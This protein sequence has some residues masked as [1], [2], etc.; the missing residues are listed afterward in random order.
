[1]KKIIVIGCPGSGKSTL[2]RELH[3]KTGIPLYH[4]DMMYWNPDK[5]T[6]EKQVFLDRLLDTLEKDEWIIDGNYASTMELRMQKCDT[7]IFLDYPTEVCLEGVSKRRGMA[8]SDMPWIESEQR[9]EEFIDFIKN[10]SLQSRPKVLNL[11]KKY[12][13]K[14]IYIFRCRTEADI[15]L[16]QL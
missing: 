1:M 11:I 3:R 8:R 6:V 14:S 7:V 2:S 10:F 9:D 15:F 13:H 12:S 4:L 16:S 5:S